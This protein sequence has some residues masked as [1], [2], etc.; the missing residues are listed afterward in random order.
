MFQQPDE[1]DTIDLAMQ[2][3]QYALSS[4]PLAG[5]RLPRA[6]FR[7]QHLGTYL[8]S[9]LFSAEYMDESCFVRKRRLVTLCR[10]KQLFFTGERFDQWDLD[11]LLHC[12]MRAPM[13]KGRPELLQVAPADLLH[14]LN[15]RN[16]RINRERVFTSLQ[17]L[18]S[19]VITI[20]GG[21]YRYMTNLLD[22]VLADARRELCLVEI[23]NDV[24][25]AFH[26][27]GLTRAARARLSL[28]RH[29]LAKW[30]H[31]ATV[32]FPGGFASDLKS[33][34]DLCRPR[35]TQKHH[36]TNRLGKALALL[37]DNHTLEH[38]KMTANSL[39]ASAPSAPARDNTSCGL[40]NIIP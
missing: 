22:R 10:D 13:S 24:A 37:T 35:T 31:G 33:L 26:Q 18:H 16:S 12:V 40:F 6:S 2:F 34:H 30:L 21:G 4:D 15:L 27:G 39:T 19:G 14:A 3:D 25:A 9:D 23:N 38:W 5:Q 17:R 36:F 32:V 29:G 7:I 8:L 20:R 1:I 11:V 28:G